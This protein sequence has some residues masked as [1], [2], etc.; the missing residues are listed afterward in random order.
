MEPRKQI[1]KLLVDAGVITVKTLERAL[2]LQKGSGKRLGELLRDMGIVTEEEVAEAIANQFNLRTVRNFANHEFPQG[3]LDLVPPRM[4]FEKLIFPLRCNDRTLAI[5]TLDPLD[6][7]TFDHLMQLTGLRIYPVLSTR[8]DI[9]A[10]VEKHYQIEG[11]EA[12]HK[13]KILLIDDSP[14]FANLLGTALTKEGY[15]V[16]VAGDGI[17]GLNLT[18]SHH[19]ELILCDLFLPRMDGYSF[20]RAMKEQ[21]EI[22]G[23]PVILVTSKASME[24]EEKALKAGFIDFIGKPI[25]PARVVERVQRALATCKN[26]HQ[27]LRNNPLGA[28]L[29]PSALTTKAACRAS[30]QH[31]EAINRVESKLTKLKQR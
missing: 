2:N 30:L 6:S 14:V 29:Q 1:G 26:E 7:E 3:L 12:S 19:P 21:N 8:E 20:M 22:A 15:E 17:E 4:A 27:S 10:A 5:A 11:K 13:P 16:L 25:M 31:R 24:E 18:L 9:L 23:I 28:G